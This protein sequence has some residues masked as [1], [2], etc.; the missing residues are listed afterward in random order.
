MT[1]SRP[2]GRTRDTAAVSAASSSLISEF[3]SMRK[4]W[5]TRAVRFV[6]TLNGPGIARAT[7]SASSTVDFSGRA[8]TIARA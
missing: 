8:S 1:A 3:T 4:A 7:T 6:T 5:K 2:P